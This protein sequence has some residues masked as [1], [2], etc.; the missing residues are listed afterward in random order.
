MGTIDGAFG[1]EPVSLLGGRVYAGSFRQLPIADGY[2]TNVFKGD[3][4]AL[5]TGGTI[6]RISVTTAG[7]PVGIFMGVSYTDATMGFIQRDYW[8]ASTVSADA[9]AY[10]CDDPWA[11]FK[12]QADATLAATAV[13]TNAAMI[14]GTGSTST[15]RSANELQAS[16]VAVTNTLPLRIVDFWD[17]D[18]IGSDFPIMLVK[19]NQGDTIIASSTHHQYYSALG[20]DTS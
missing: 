2:A 16:S 9:Y 6:E 1:M 7:M 4:V 10:V 19:W 17:R 8:P 3:V 20:T 12:I 18:E 5:V 15:G 11:L 13:G 14:N